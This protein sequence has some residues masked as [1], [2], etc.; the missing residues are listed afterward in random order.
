MPSAERALS[1]SLDFAPRIE[2]IGDSTSEISVVSID[3]LN[4]SFR[5]RSEGVVG[6]WLVGWSV[7]ESTGDRVMS[8]RTIK[9]GSAVVS[10]I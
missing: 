1:V 3:S 9:A 10:G 6:F 7:L 2:F 5:F 8:G 4:E